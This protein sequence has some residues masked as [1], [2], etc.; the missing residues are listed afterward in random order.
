MATI[1]S[2]NSLIPVLVTGIQP[3]RVRAVNNKIRRSP[4]PKDLG[5][6][7][8]PHPPSCSGLTRGSIPV[9]ADGCGVDARVKPEH[10]GAWGGSKK[11]LTAYT[12]VSGTLSA[13]ATDDVG[14]GLN[15]LDKAKR[16]SAT[17]LPSIGGAAW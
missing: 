14:T 1:A 6:E 17:A 15:R 12:P 3:P 9:A 7:A 2:S 11:P 16:A 5:A 4:A 10:D 13:S 8:Q